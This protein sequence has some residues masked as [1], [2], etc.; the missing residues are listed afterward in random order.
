MEWRPPQSPGS[1]SSLNGGEPTRRET[2]VTETWLTPPALSQLSSVTGPGKQVLFQLRE[3]ALAPHPSGRGSAAW[4]ALGLPSPGLFPL[5][6]G[7]S[8]LVLSFDRAE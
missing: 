1:A 3:L 7:M 5:V 4:E 8:Q 2:P 6:E